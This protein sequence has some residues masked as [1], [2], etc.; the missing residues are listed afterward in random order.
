MLLATL[1]DRGL[2]PC[3]RCLIP[4]IDLD[5]L[6]LT[7]DSKGRISRVRT[8]LQDTVAKGRDMLYKGGYVVTS[9]LIDAV[10]KPLSQ[11]P[12]MVR[13]VLLYVFLLN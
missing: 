5:K 13:A 3:P 4:S 9:T 6:G 1:R 11:V 12:T 8:W 10:L 7:S 2:C